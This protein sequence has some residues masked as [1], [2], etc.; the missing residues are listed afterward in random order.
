MQIKLRGTRIKSEDSWDH[1]KVSQNR[2]FQNLRKITVNHK[3]LT[4]TELRH[5]YLPRKL[6]R[7]LDEDFLALSSKMFS[8]LTKNSSTLAIK[9]PV[10]TQLMLLL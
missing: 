9:S 6:P 7:S 4:R 10:L 3:G 8:Q 5:R 2:K 1:N